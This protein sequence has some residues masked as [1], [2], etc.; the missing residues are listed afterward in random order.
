MEKFKRKKKKGFTLIELMLVVAIILVLLGF[1]VPKFSA[2]QNKA[3]TAKAIN[4][5]KQIETAAMASYGDN[6]GSFNEEDVRSCISNLTSAGGASI[7]SGGSDQLINISYE[8]DS[9]TYV[10]EIDAANNSYK[11]RKGNDQIFPKNTSG[12]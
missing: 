4:T 9:D 5:A 12:E 11:V 6:D 2:Y 8:S 1:L 3:K 7:E 10:L